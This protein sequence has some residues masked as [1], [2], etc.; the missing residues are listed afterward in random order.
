MGILLFVLIILPSWPAVA[1]TE[2]KDPDSFLK[3]GIG[4]RP[5][6]MGGAFT[7]VADD[8]NSTYYNA[9]GLSDMKSW[10]VFTAKSD[11]FDFDVKYDYTN[12]VIPLMPGKVLGVA[13]A[14]LTTDG[15][16]ITRDN[17]PAILGYVT[18]KEKALVLSYGHRLSEYW[19]L[20]GSVKKIDQKVY[21]G[22]SEGTEA[23]FGILYTPSKTVRFGVNFQDCLP[24]EIT[25]NTGSRV[26]IP[27]TIRGG[28]ALHI[29]DWGSIIALDINKVD[30]RD[31]QFD[32][33]W[34]YQF[35]EGV[36]GRVGFHDGDVTA[37]FS[38]IRDSWRLDYAFRKSELGDTSRIATGFRFGS[39][40]FERW[41]RR[42]SKP[43]CGEIPVKLSCKITGKSD[44][45][46]SADCEHGPGLPQTA[47]AGDCES[48]NPASM[49]PQPDINR[50][51]EY[52][53]GVQRVGALPVEGG[54]KTEEL[55]RRGNKQLLAGEYDAAMATFRD[56][57]RVN[58]QLEDAHLKLAGIYHF[59]K[60]YEDAIESYKDAIA[61]NP[62]NVDNYLNIATL[63]AKLK[64]FD[65]A[66]EAARLV[67]ELSPGSPK[68]QMAA[69]MVETFG[70]QGSGNFV[71]T[72]SSG[73]RLS[74]SPS[75]PPAGEV[76]FENERAGADENYGSKP[77]TRTVQG[78][79][80]ISELVH[81]GE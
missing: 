1:G 52:Q 53:D 4:A 62:A 12:L 67:V 78:R 32:G 9:A 81:A 69:R 15:I 43:Q 47:T 77:K 65:K 48:G 39:F 3:L 6:G 8:A 42:P 64:E 76:V 58:P 35:N 33:G 34:E 38:Y 16:P 54:A 68:A 79:R 30:G 7:A 41:F 57:T 26:K 24:T 70:G 55:L 28:M 29:H 40:L 56:L 21:I 20:G 60:R 37:G 63:Y 50:M 73:S 36:V 11:S 51:L 2:M 22:K 27:L 18:D 74:L 71:E 49:Q 17:V 14:Q 75:R 25:W 44:C 72:G 80:R 46:G 19:A 59:Q 66:A 10:E 5:L 13:M 61:A 23:D 45:S 31:V